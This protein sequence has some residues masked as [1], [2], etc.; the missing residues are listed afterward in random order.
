MSFAATVRDE[1]RRAA[2]ARFRRLG[3]DDDAARLSAEAGTVEADPARSA[4]D[5]RR[6]WNVRHAARDAPAAPAAFVVDR[7]SHLPTSG[8]ALDLAGG[9]GRHAVWLARRGLDTILVDVS[10]EACRRA[11]H[12]AAAAGVALEVHRADLSVDGPPDGPWDVVLSSD[13]L[14]RAVWAEAAG[15]LAPGGVLLVCQPTVTNLERHDRPS[16]RWLLEDGELGR[17]AAS[18]PDLEVL[19]ISEGWRSRGR[20]EAWLVARRHACQVSASGTV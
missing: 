15:R 5:A 2:A 4:D 12:A 7:A 20:H 6:R 9:T 13:F 11:R 16:R 3:R 17:L 19:E 18:W 8:R 10:D 1:L 14:D